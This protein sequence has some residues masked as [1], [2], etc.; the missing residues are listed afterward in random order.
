MIHAFSPED[1]R[2]MQPQEAIEILKFGPCLAGRQS[3]GDDPLR[4]PRPSNPAKDAPP[5]THLG[6]VQKAWFLDRLRRS[7]AAWKIWG[8]SFGTLVWRTDIQNLAQWQGP[9]LAGL[10]LRADERWLLRRARR[11][12]RHGAARGHHRI[13]RCRRRQAQFLGR[14]GLEG[15]AARPVRPGRV[16]FVTGSISAQGL[17]ESL[18]Y[19]IKDDDPLRA[20]SYRGPERG[21]HPVD[22]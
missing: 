15:P 9:I 18:P 22:H 2:W 13:R 6:A 8:H 19:N 4:R 7:T 20:L 17:A 5:Q 14:P 21:L 11:D 1:Y 10:R 12:L 16:E 3:A